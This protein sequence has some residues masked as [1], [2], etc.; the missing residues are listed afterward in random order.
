MP[1]PTC[2]HTMAQTHTNATEILYG[3]PRCGTITINS[4][5]DPSRVIAVY[6]PKLID[7]CRELQAQVV[8]DRKNHVGAESLLGI[9]HRLGISE[10]INLPKDRPNAPKEPTS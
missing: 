7:Y 5:T 3:C 8:A 2:D 4:S 1:C 6:V 9:L 10:A